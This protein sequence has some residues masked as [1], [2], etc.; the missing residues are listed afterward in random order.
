MSGPPGSGIAGVVASGV[1][2]GGVSAGGVGVGDLLADPGFAG[3]VSEVFGF[4]HMP[5]FEASVAAMS[6]ED[7]ADVLAGADQYDEA[8]EEAPVAAALKEEPR[9][10]GSQLLDLFIEAANAGILSE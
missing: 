7:I 3:T 2:A 5:D 8:A 9:G 1:G 6:P 4:A 10:T